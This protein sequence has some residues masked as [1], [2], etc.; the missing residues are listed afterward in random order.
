MNE[1]ETAMIA[2]VTAELDKAINTVR[3]VK[4]HVN[5][6]KELLVLLPYEATHDSPLFD[7]SM[8][9]INKHIA[10]IEELL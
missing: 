8:R 9:D 2:Q 4:T 1:Q 3:E 7:L 5:A 10:H 6:I